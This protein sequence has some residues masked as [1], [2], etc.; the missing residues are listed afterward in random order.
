MKCLKYVPGNDRQNISIDQK[1]AKNLVKKL[2]NVSDPNYKSICKYLKAVR[3]SVD[4][5]L[6][7]EKEFMLLHFSGPIESVTFEKGCLKTICSKF[8]KNGNKYL[9]ISVPKLT[10]LK[11][12]NTVLTKNKTAE[13]SSYDGIKL[14]IA[15]EKGKDKEAKYN[16]YIVVRG[17]E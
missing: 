7:R 1:I 13:F 9:I 5:E 12:N 14:Q 8:P 16:V 11:R 10:T 17:T 3:L 6:I 2:S 4:E 15:K